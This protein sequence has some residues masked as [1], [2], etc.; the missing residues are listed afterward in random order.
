MARH[1]R[2]VQVTY[3]GQ[4][5][6]WIIPGPSGRIYEFAPGQVVE[7]A[8]EDASF[9]LEDAVRGLDFQAVVSE[10]PAETP[11][12]EDSPKVEIAEPAIAEEAVSE[13]PL[14]TAEE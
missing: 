13:A 2:T 9:F 5:D 6:R 12:W 7:V 10:P 11:L 1:K 3:R 4:I 14:S 8:A